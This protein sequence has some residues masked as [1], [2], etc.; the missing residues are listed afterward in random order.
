MYVCF[1]DDPVCRFSRVRMYDCFVD[2]PECCR[3]RV[4]MCDCVLDDP[5]GV[6]HSDTSTHKLRT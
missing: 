5:V 6:V 3:S 2:D 4:R 1:V